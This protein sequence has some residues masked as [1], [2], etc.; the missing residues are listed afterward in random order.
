MRK[1]ASKLPNVPRAPGRYRTS[2]LTVP[3]RRVVAASSASRHRSPL[4]MR[5]R[6]QCEPAVRPGDNPLITRS[7]GQTSS[8]AP[9]RTLDRGSARPGSA[10]GEQAVASEHPPQLD[11]RP[12]GPLQHRRPT[13]QPHVVEA[14]ELQRAVSD[15]HHRASGEQA[16]SPETCD[17]A[18]GMSHRTCLPGTM[19]SAQTA[20]RSAK[21]RV[22]MR[23]RCTRA[24]SA[25]LAM[26]PRKTQPNKITPARPKITQPLIADSGQRGARGDPP[27]SGS[28]RTRPPGTAPRAR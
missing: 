22:S 1:R 13:E 15:V 10:A 3:T 17:G 14:R 24:G 8:E 18:A 25:L 21:R 19:R 4:S 7:T 2:R 20:A 6:G 12:A 5:R 28:G 27:W 23:Q 11:A 16:G 26:R 9:R